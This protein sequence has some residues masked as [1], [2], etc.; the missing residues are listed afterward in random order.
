MK[1]IHA[2]QNED[3]TYRVEICGTTKDTRYLGRCKYNDTIEYKTEIPRAKLNIE[4]LILADD[5]K[6][7]VSLT[8]DTKENQNETI[9]Q[10]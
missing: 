1:E 3:G 9:I 2:Y 4:A 5:E 8:L 6:K 7:L 10:M